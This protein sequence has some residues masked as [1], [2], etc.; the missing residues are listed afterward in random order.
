VAASAAGAALDGLGRHAEAEKLL[1]RSYEIL[2]SD[3]DALPAYR[4][5][6]Q[7][8]LRTLYSH[9]GHPPAT[10]RYAF[11]AA[12]AGAGTGTGAAALHAAAQQ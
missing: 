7:G 9:W 6:T 12:A 8:Y 4:V 3:A 10:S 11:L 2:C 5:L 1:T